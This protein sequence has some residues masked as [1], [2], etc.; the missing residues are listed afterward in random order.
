MKNKNIVLML[1]SVAVALIMMST[2]TARPMVED[3]ATRDIVTG[4][5]YTETSDELTT[6]SQ[7][8]SGVTQNTDEQYFPF[9]DLMIEAL[10]GNLNPDLEQLLGSDDFLNAI[11]EIDWESVLSNPALIDSLSDL[12]LSAEAEDALSDAV[13]VDEVA[14]IISS[15]SGMTLNEILDI[16]LKVLWIIYLFMGLGYIMDDY[17]LPWA[18]GVYDS[19]TAFCE[20]HNVPFLFAFIGYSILTIVVGFAQLLALT[21]W[22]LWY[23]LIE[24]GIIDSDT[25][26][27]NVAGLSTNKL[28]KLS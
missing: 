15:L 8:V 17:F 20:Q 25:S 22:P 24:N 4:S 16:I 18:Q 1:C 27:C 13:D 9:F 5:V 21:L 7:S 10:Y 28:V 14:S 6:T 23:Y 26:S 3:P 19:F 2:V 12:E 11:Y